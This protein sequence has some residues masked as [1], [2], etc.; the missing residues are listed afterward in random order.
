M[1]DLTT[2]NEVS[3]IVRIAMSILI[4]GIFGLER[5]A[6]RQ[7]AGIRTY[8]L[9]CLAST[10]IMLTN[11]YITQIYHMGDPTRMAAQVIS[12][13]GFL[14]AGTILVTERNQIKGLTTA[15]GLWA[16]ASLGLAIGVGFY[17]IAIVG[18][19][20]MVLTIMFFAPLKGY[21]QKRS[22]DFEVLI[23][24]ESTEALNRLLVHCAAKGIDV[25]EMRSGM[26]KGELLKLP[27]NRV[28]LTG[29]ELL[30]FLSFHLSENFDHLKLIQE[31]TT[32]SGVKYI[33]EIK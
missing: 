13:I 32:I 7:P 18:A 3:V 25:T 33:E 17:F 24:L 27:P 11:Q 19:I 6:R 23:L 10:I 5:S 21:V 22:R 14:G 9:V 12:G 20:A 29:Q 16:V 4:G 8:I 15:A 31:I 1:I 2:V 26:G 28:S 30:Y